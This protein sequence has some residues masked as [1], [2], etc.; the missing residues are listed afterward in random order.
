MTATIPPTSIALTYLARGADVDCLKHFKCFADSYKLYDAGT[1]HQLYIIFKGFKNK[2]YLLEAF[3]LFKNLNY[4]PI[5]L[6][7]KNLDIGAYIEW[8]KIVDKK[9]ICVLNTASEILSPFWLYK[10]SVNLSIHNVGLVGATG[11]FESLHEYNNIFSPFPNVHVRTTGF[12]IDRDL[13]LCIAADY[14]ITSKDEA[15]MFESGPKSLTKQVLMKGKDIL[16]VGRNGRGYSPEFWPHSDTF[17]QGTQSNLLIADNQTRNFSK[18]PWICKQ[19]YVVR[20]WGQYIQYGNWLKKSSQC[21]HS[22]IKLLWIYLVGLLS[23][24]IE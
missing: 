24:R 11:S 23:R 13:F 2:S 7:D 19:D 5:H 15:F 9:R 22:S 21:R 8:A 10:L 1:P 12:M 18:M 14:N 6:N 16:L 17:R 3:D 4:I 20:T